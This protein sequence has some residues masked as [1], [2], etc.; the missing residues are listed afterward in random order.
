MAPSPIIPVVLFTTVGIFIAMLYGEEMAESQRPLL[1]KPH[2]ESS[3]GGFLDQVADAVGRF[4]NIIVG[5]INAIWSVVN[6]F[7]SLLTFNVPD[8]PWYIRTLIGSIMTTSVIWIIIALIKPGG[9]G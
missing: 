1:E 3:G 8:A 2:E 5:F 9:N 7:I 4:I 6:F